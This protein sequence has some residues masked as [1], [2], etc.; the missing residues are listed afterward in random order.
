MEEQWRSSLCNKSGVKELKSYQKEVFLHLVHGNDCFVCQPTGSGKSLLM[1]TGWVS[2]VSCKNK[3]CRSLA[4]L[5]VVYGFY[6]KVRRNNGM[7]MKLKWIT[8]R[9][10]YGLCSC[11]L[12]FD[13][14][15]RCCLV[16]WNVII[17]HSSKE[18]L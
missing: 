10:I 8:K 1:A 18:L 7:F 9:S 15:Q 4:W 5:W 12:N 16:W 6:H 13:I 14:S 17:L 11:V 3:W 2:G